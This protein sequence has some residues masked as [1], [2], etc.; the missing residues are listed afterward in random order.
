[1]VPANRKPRISAS[2]CRAR[3]KRRAA[4]CILTGRKTSPSKGHTTSWPWHF[5]RSWTTTSRRGTRARRFPFPRKHRI[6]AEDSAVHKHSFHRSLRPDPSGLA[7]PLRIVDGAVEVVRSLV[8]FELAF[9]SGLLRFG[10]KRGGLG[11]GQWLEASR[12]IKSLLQVGEGFATGDNHTGG[13]A[14]DIAETFHRRHRVA[15]E[16]KSSAHG[17]HAENA[18]F[19]FQEHGEDFFL[20][21]FIVGVHRVEGHLD[22]V[23]MKLAGGGALEHFK[24]HVWIFV[25]GET[26]VTD[27]AGLFRFEN[28]FHS[29]GGG[30]DALR[31]GHANDFVELEKVDVVGLEAAERFVELHGGGFF[32]LAVDFGHE[33]SLLAVAVAQR[34][35]HADFAGPVIVVPAVVEEVDAAIECGADNTDGFLFVGLNTEMPAAQANHGDAFA[36]AAEPAIGNAVFRA[37][38]P[39]FS[40]RDTSQDGGGQHGAQELAAS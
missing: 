31:V 26:D 8:A 20:E 29:T 27:F 37:R 5:R 4:L 14:H 22:G 3:A 17:L 23:E 35:A 6:P 15:F 7:E 9:A 21:T 28:G 10:E 38:G 16:E 11:G 19:V 36:T 32:R 12:H 2:A 25:A 18:N 39:E 30:E 24:M 40:A 34:L 1:M 13:Q 33:E